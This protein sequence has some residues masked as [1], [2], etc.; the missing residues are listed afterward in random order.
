MDC[1]IEH[2]NVI[3]LKESL[4]LQSCPVLVP[5][6]IA[7]SVMKQSLSTLEYVHKLGIVH[8]TFRLF[9]ATIAHQADGFRILH[10]WRIV[11]VFFEIGVSSS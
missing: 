3:R 11:Y 9:R 10:L 1:E 6:K 2:P 8:T 7:P 5:H 4:P